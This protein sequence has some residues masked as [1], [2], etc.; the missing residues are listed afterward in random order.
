[1]TH[2]EGYVYTYDE[3]EIGNVTEH[4][5]TYTYDGA[6]KLTEAVETV[7][8]GGTLSRTD[9]YAYDRNG[10]NLMKV[11]GYITDKKEGEEETG[12]IGE[13]SLCDDV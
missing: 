10:N 8:G 1:M 3:A 12:I 2:P 6:N 5:V 9:S 4:K 13:Q 7:E 11:S